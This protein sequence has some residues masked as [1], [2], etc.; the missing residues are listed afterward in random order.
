M[1]MWPEGIVGPPELP[2][3]APLR[4]ITAPLA[5]MIAAIV[6]AVALAEQI[7]AVGLASGWPG[8]TWFRSLS[9]LAAS[10]RLYPDPGLF[11]PAQ[12]WS[13]SFVHDVPIADARTV[14]AAWLGVIVDAGLLLVLLRAWERW[15]G[16]L[17]TGLLVLIA[18]PLVAMVHLRHVVET[19]PLATSASV[20]AFVL[21][22]TMM[23]LPGRRLR[24][25]LGYWAVVAVGMVPIHL[26]LRLVLAGYVGFE[27]ARSALVAPHQLVE[28]VLGLVV[29]TVFGALIGAFMHRIMPY[30]QARWA[31]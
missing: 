21:A 25:R 10:A 9:L 17:L 24:L 11:T 16:A 28:H 15:V 27:M 6:V 23:L 26:D 18:G 8:E 4:S 7:A 12:M 14:I 13:A 22:A 29:A 20:V 2:E 5:S 30:V 1:I 31:K 19:P 3:Q